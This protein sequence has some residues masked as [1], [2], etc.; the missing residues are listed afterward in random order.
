[1]HYA[2]RTQEFSEIGYHHWKELT[3]LNDAVNASTI[4]ALQWQGLTALVD[5]HDPCCG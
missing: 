1:M 3:Q 5:L 2:K 4:I